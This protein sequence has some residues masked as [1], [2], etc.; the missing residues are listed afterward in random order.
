MDS[1]YAP[2]GIY[3]VFNL[4]SFNEFLG[5][6]KKRRKLRVIKENLIN[7]NE[8]LQSFEFLTLFDAVNIFLSIFDIELYFF[9][10]MSSDSKN[11]TGNY[12]IAIGILLILLFILI[13]GYICNLIL[14]I[15]LKKKG[16]V[17]IFSTEKIPV[18]MFS[19]TVCFIYLITFFSF[20][21]G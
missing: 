7:N 9:K 10:Q 18:K 17:R 20:V 16:L 14:R 19:D 13:L 6:Y 3:F 2:I 5:T 12:F 21:I 15:I 1:L 11:I 4:I 8:F